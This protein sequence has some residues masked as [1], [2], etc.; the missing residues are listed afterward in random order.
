[1]QYFTS[2]LF[3][4]NDRK[5]QSQSSATITSSLYHVTFN[6][7]TKRQR[8]QQAQ[9]INNCTKSQPDIAAK[10]EHNIK[11]SS[12]VNLSKSQVEISSQTPKSAISIL[13]QIANQARVKFTKQ[14][15]KHRNLNR[16]LCAS[17]SSA[18]ET[19]SYSEDDDSTRPETVSLVEL[20][21]RLQ[22]DNTFE[23][24]ED[25]EWLVVEPDDTSQQISP[26]QETPTS[27]EESHNQVIEID[28][29]M[30]LDIA[31][32]EII[33]TSWEPIRNDPTESGL[34]LFKG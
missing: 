15:S 7:D 18:T 16:S 33:K 9:N 22:E 2:K 10:C 3:V 17:F 19:C 5:A 8:S 25:G 29:Q 24:K 26:T 6:S 11:K 32:V 28:E 23:L 21:N 14:R 13:N 30:A 31:D 4:Y 1:M 27:N 12:T 34:L 20:R